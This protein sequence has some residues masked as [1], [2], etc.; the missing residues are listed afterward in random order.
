MVSVLKPFTNNDFTIDNSYEFVGKISHFPNADDYFKA[1]IDA[2]SL[3]TNVPLRDTVD[4]LLGQCSQRQLQ[5][6]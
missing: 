3:L 1:S 5:Q 2:A 4:M 6:C